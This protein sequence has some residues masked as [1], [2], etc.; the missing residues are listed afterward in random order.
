MTIAQ[1]ETP[2]LICDLD[3][4]ERNL[5]AMQS[6]ADA[7]GVGLRP[8]IKT[9]KTPALAK[10]QLELGACG[11]TCAKLGE[12][13]V[14]ADEAG[15]TDL[16]IAYSL[17]GADKAARLR[18]LQERAEVRVSVV[19]LAQAEIL[20]AALGGAPVKVRLNVDTGLDRDGMTAARAV[21]DAQRIA[22]LPGIELIGVFTHEGQAHKGHNFDEVKAIGRQAAQQLVD[23]AAA[24]RAAGL[25]CDEVAPGGTP[26]AADLASYPGVTEVRPGT[27]L[28]YDMMC[29]ECMDLTAADC[30][31]RVLTTVVDL[32]AERRVIVDGGSKTFFNDQF[33]SWGRAMC[34]EHPDLRLEKCSEEHGHAEWRGEG[35]P[36][37]KLGDRL[38]WIPSHVCPVV[39][40][41]DE[42]TA[43]RGE[44]VVDT[45]RISARGKVR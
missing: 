26:T 6:A 34:V 28:F 8:H 39:N 12:A 5:R 20:S 10:W 22:A 16:F 36:P 25:P 13:E 21:A 3:I 41:F 14:M 19:S 7:G 15:C 40:L 29:V 32:P 37:V 23:V 17:L 38:T 9:H 24:L 1:L 42:M 11:L 35:A 31:L 27:Y 2:G 4:T 45:L 18:A 30:G 44:E 43:V 33:A